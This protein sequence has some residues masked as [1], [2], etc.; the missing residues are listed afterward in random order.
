MPLAGTGSRG[1]TTGAS[2][3]PGA[4]S[5]PA[6]TGAA[7]VRS[8]Q[9]EAPTGYPIRPTGVAIFAMARGRPS[10]CPAQRPLPDRSALVGR[11]DL[12]LCP[13]AQRSCRQP[14]QRADR[15]SQGGRFQA[16]LACYRS[17]P[18]SCHLALSAVAASPEMRARRALPPDWIALHPPPRPPILLRVLHVL[19]PGDRGLTRLE[20][21]RYEPLA[22]GSL[23]ARAGRHGHRGVR[24]GLRAQ[25]PSRRRRGSRPG[26]FFTCW[27]F[28]PEPCL[29]MA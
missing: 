9:G 18:C 12:P 17:S 1:V 29:G 14:D 21:G 13:A 3:V 28:I 27:L 24:A 22:G 7:D 15:R 2:R 16:A 8:P 26:S 10:F 4:G 25:E 5:A 11:R 23:F 20:R 6:P 19:I